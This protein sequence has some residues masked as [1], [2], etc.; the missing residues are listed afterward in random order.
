[1]FIFRSQEFDY[2]NFECHTDTYSGSSILLTIIAAVQNE[3]VLSCHRVNG[4]CFLADISEVT[5]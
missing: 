5:I 1:M 3:V 4:L 2:L